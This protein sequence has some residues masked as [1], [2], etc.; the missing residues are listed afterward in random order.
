MFH[1]NVSVY[2]KLSFNHDAILNKRGGDMFCP[3]CGKEIEDDVVVCVHC[4]RLV[5]ERK[6]NRAEFKQSKT[7]MGA[8]VPVFGFDWTDHWCLH[9][10]RR[11][12]G[13]PNI[14]EGMGNTFAICVALIVILSLAL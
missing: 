7:G 6:E 1:C 14:F 3:K 12:R 10:S 4:G 5:E 13:S 9:L 8:F 2:N 11:H